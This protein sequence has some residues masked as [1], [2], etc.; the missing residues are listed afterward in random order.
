[1]P[2]M[3]GVS[4]K[5][6]RPVEAA[7]SGKE[8]GEQKRRSQPVAKVQRGR[9]PEILK[10]LNGEGKSVDTILRESIDLFLDIFE[11]Y[12]FQRE[13]FAESSI[14]K[15]V[16]YYRQLV[17][18]AD[19]DWMHVLKLKTVNFVNV[20]RGFPLAKSRFSDPSPGVLLGGVC[21]RWCK[22]LISKQKSN[23]FDE[24]MFCQSL[25]ETVLRSK[26]GLPRPGD[27]YLA[28]EL[29]STFEELTTEPPRPVE[30]KRGFDLMFA[31]PPHAS[32][33]WHDSAEYA[34][35]TGLDDRVWHPRV[36]TTL[37]RESV[38]HQLVRTVRELYEGKHYS[39]ED[40][41]QVFVPSTS[42]NYIDS[43]VL[44]GALGTLKSD[45]LVHQ[46]LY[47]AKVSLSVFNPQD[48]ADE[49]VASVSNLFS[50]PFDCVV[51]DSSALDAKFLPFM[52]HVLSTA[53][54]EKKRV[55]LV[56]LSEALKVRVISKMPPYTT[57]AL[58]PLQRFLWKQLVDNPA[59]RLLAEPKVT[60][61]YLTERL[62]VNLPPR[63]GYNSGDYKAATNGLHSWASE[64]VCR[65]IAHFVGLSSAE[66]EL[67]VSSL[68][69]HWIEYPSQLWNGQGAPME[70]RRGKNQRRG[71]LMGSITSFPVLC[72]INAAMS[73][74]AMEVD[75]NRVISLRDSSL[76]IN[77]D[78]V[79][80]K[81]T[82][83]GLEVW[84]RLTSFVGLT[85][86][87]GKSYFSR[88]YLNINSTGFVR[89]ESR[90]NYI[91]GERVE[92]RST[93]F[94]PVQYVNTGLL[95]SR[96][97]SEGGSAN[98]VA[99]G[100]EKSLGQCATELIHRAP[101]VMHERL[102][103]KFIHY[104]KDKLD[105]YHVPYFI[106]EWLGGYGLP[107][108]FNEVSDLDTP[109]SFVENPN[110][111]R[112]YGPSELDLRIATGI[113]RGW[114]KKRPQA[115]T[116]APSW[117]M[118][119]YAMSRLPLQKEVKVEHEATYERLRR[120]FDT[121]YGRLCFEAFAKLP[122]D[123][124]WKHEDA[125]SDDDDPEDEFYLLEPDADVN[126]F[127]K[128]AVRHNERL[129]NAKNAASRGSIH[130]PLPLS[131]LLGDRPS[132]VLPCL[133]LS[134]SSQNRCFS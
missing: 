51:F 80:F 30:D 6:I 14:R 84:S 48:L 36:S 108:L 99:S 96:K 24:R 66:T 56:A 121:V 41:Y 133:P 90:N 86:S 68:V 63:Y 22:L 130:S 123:P 97:R 47:D 69:G 26:G 100:F 92:F 79:L 64:L 44:G 67:F 27:D 16:K 126:S 83:F 15:A 115:V 49:R 77:G 21:Y 103:A 53:M 95:K 113:L 42:A 4:S 125:D 31:Y 124:S 13:R 129:W 43:R 61:E 40:R 33:S 60:V 102:L 62:G 111:G 131:I 7:H 122:L 117:L 54:S 116:D 109:L 104:N 28:K 112:R 19:G 87:I 75:Q 37:N 5:K 93:P 1:M 12:G 39:I 88:Y 81:C 46:L 35:S 55:G 110:T 8:P 23:D 85:P 29:L 34:K 73:R 45:P 119:K 32:S 58:K 25:L 120:G 17:D 72:L 52:D 59:F 11:L 71:Q 20:H 57:T 107:M 127:A 76:C 78:D 2:M 105:Q 65:S 98:P 50:L 89:D 118:H 134:F 38:A 3:V 101:K 114:S 10:E 70:F 94:H 9:G 74:W 18:I 128:H 132:S 91:R 106:P 82:D